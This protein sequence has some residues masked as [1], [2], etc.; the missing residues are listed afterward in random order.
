[1]D[2]RSLVMAEGERRMVIDHTLSLFVQ[3]EVRRHVYVTSKTFL[4]FIGTFLKLLG[5]RREEDISARDGMLNGL[6]K[7]HQT[8]ETVARMKADLDALKPVLQVRQQQPP[9]PSP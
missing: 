2:R 8:N 4:D 3:Q 6:H 7:L 5:K 9:P 1:M